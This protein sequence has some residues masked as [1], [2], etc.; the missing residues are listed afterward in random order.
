VRSEEAVKLG[1][2]NTI[3]DGEDVVAG[4]IELAEAIAANGAGGVRATKNALIRSAEISSFLA[5]LELENRNQ[6]VC[7]TS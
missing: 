6:V 7:R 4:A 1:L 5:A 2:L 3:V